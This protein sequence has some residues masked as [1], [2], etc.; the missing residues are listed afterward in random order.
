MLILTR[1]IGEILKIGSDVDVTVLSIKGNQVRL[2]ITAPNGIS[3]HRE[4]IFQKIQEESQENKI[5]D[6][7][8]IDNSMLE[9]ALLG[10]METEFTL[11]NILYHRS[12]SKLAKILLERAARKGHKQAQ[13]L[14]DK[15]KYIL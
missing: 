6:L 4:E 3:V 2:G 7:D 13:E 15:D 1:K 5:T 10:D 12:K 14:L 9:L 8:L 11:G